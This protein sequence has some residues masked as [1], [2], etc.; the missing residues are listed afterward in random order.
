MRPD[1]QNISTGV[2]SD[3]KPDLTRC[4]ELIVTL[5]YQVCWSDRL[6]YQVCRSNGPSHKVCRPDRSFSRCACL[7]VNHFSTRCLPDRLYTR[8]VCLRH[9]SFYQMCMPDSQ[10]TK[11]MCMPESQSDDL[12][13]CAGLTISFVGVSSG[14]G[15][16]AD[17]AG[18]GCG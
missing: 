6:S 1:N 18:S 10:S 11:L 13:R 7:R 2:Q 8:C 16:G 15:E 5:F 12:T 4:E 9:R 17:R 14:V 3:R